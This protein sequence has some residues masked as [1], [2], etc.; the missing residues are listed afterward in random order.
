M[1]LRRRCRAKLFSTA[2]F[3]AGAA[4]AALGF[5]GTPALA[6]GYF[7]WDYDE[8]RIAP[9]REWN[10]RPHRQTAR[11][12]YGRAEAE[13][14]GTPSAREAEP[15]VERPLFAVAS[16]ADQHVSIYNHHGLV[17]RSAIS[18]GI[19]GHSTPKGIFTIIGRER[20]HRSNIYSGAPMP[21]MQRITWSGIAMHLRRRAGP[22]GLARLHPAPRRVRR[23]AVGIDQD[24]RARRHLAARRDASRIRAPAAAGAKIADSGGSQQSRAR[25]RLAAGARCRRRR[26]AASQSASIC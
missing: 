17:A 12:K 19:A 7:P 2:V 24:R 26:A 4:A 10:P 13:K 14:A 25:C 16:I 23:E 15:V 8:P 20:F 22:S 18:T 5:E 6:Q 11:K 21:F 3:A 1:R 9:T